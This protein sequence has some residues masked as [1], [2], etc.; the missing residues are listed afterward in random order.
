MTPLFFSRHVH[1]IGAF[2]DH[3]LTEENS[4]EFVRDEY[5]LEFLDFLHCSDALNV[6]HK[7]DGLPGTAG[8]LD[9]HL[10][11]CPGQA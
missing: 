9:M 1:R 3:I 8:P 4:L 5:H 11:I 10:I 7:I 6:L 2:L